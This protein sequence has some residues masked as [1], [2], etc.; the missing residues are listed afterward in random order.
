M[1]D[2][3]M[4]KNRNDCELAVPGV[5]S[6]MLY[7][8][9]SGEV[10]GINE[11]QAMS[12]EKYG[13]GNYIPDVTGLFWSFRAMV[14]M[15]G[16]MAA[17]AAAVALLAWKKKL[18]DFPW[19]LKL[20]PWLLPAAYLANSAGWYV[21]EGGRQP[22]IV[23]GLQKTADAVSPNLTT[24]DVGITVIGFTLIYL[25]LAML[26]LYAAFHFI[27]KTSVSASEGSDA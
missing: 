1:A 4:E 11:L 7:N 16:L 19:A 18:L 15:G 10:K 27:R 14:G 13:P 20:L 25:L 5:F 22:W 12:V 2:I 23:V 8:K 9:P 17:I 3:N 26:A 21:A 24:S 6:F